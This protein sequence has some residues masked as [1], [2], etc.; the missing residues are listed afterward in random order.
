[1]DSAYLSQFL[2]Q[3]VGGHHHNERWIHAENLAEF[4][5]YIVVPI[6]VTQS[7]GAGIGDQA[8]A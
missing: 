1:M 6:E 3:N 4:N 7:F 5:L 8:M 2:L